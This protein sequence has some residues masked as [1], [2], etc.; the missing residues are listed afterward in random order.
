M[1]SAMSIAQKRKQSIVRKTPRTSGKGLPSRIGSK[2]L[3]GTRIKK[4]HRYAPGTLALKEI[5]KC[6]KE[7][8]LYIKKTPF[9]RLIK[10][11]VI[12]QAYIPLRIQAS[13]LG[14]LQEYA[15]SLLDNTPLL[16]DNEQDDDK[17]DKDEQEQDK[18]DQDVR[19]QDVQGRDFQASYNQEELDDD[20][21]DDKQTLKQRLEA[22]ANEL[23][24]AAH[25]LT[26]AKERSEDSLRLAQETLEGD[27]KK[28]A[29]QFHR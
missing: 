10:E 15:E 14:V 1:A 22:Y 4:G 23:V 11:L 8:L 2:K 29:R 26:V 3:P 5:R 25:A 12:D 28:I 20:S 21:S 18:Q 19:D 17:Q 16:L 24:A 9:A 13:A 6:Q 7:S 27:A